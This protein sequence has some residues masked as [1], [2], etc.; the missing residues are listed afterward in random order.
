MKLYIS[1]LD[2]LFNKQNIIKINIIPHIIKF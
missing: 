1:Y 2:I